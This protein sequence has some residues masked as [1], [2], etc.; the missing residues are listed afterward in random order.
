MEMSYATT[1]VKLTSAVFVL[2]RIVFLLTS[3]FMLW[4][5]NS[6][7][8]IFITYL[9]NWLMLCYCLFLTMTHLCVF[10]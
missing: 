1:L 7:T 8:L 4:Y 10:I 2:T 9:N 5:F 3:Q 6:T